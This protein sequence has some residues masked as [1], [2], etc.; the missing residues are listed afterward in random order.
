MSQ[1]DPKAAVPLDYERSG[2]SGWLAIVQLLAWM[3]IICGAMGVW[4]I[5]N[6]VVEQIGVAV[7]VANITGETLRRN[8]LTGLNW[9]HLTIVLVWAIPKIMLMAASFRLR[10]LRPGAHQWYAT[11]LYLML[12]APV[13]IFTWGAIRNFSMRQQTF[14]WAEHLHLWNVS[15][16]YVA[17]YMLLPGVLLML[18]LRPQVRQFFATGR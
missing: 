12:A 18:I 9:E 15:A 14:S 2:D 6:F 3:G 10:R 16:W 13:L 8:V 11:A 4:Q 7:K 1:L 17:H 5:A